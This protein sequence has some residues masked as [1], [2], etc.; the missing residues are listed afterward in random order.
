MP[1]VPLLGFLVLIVI[2][3]LIVSSNNKPSTTTA[4]RP[5]TIITAAAAPYPAPSEQIIDRALSVIRKQHN[6]ILS[7]K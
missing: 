2:I 7:S 3:I 5:S 6:A 4:N 1:K